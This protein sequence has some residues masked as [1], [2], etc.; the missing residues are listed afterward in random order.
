MTVDRKLIVKRYMETDGTVGRVIPEVVV[1]RPL[2]GQVVIRT[3]NF[4]C[5]EFRLKSGYLYAY[6]SL[7]PFGKWSVV[8]SNY[9]R[10]YF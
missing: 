9:Q 1:A 4:T 5:T 7:D 2:A 8:Y 6:I 10:M 3:T